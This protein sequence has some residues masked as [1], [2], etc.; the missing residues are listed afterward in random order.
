[1][2]RA[3]QIAQPSCNHYQLR[4]AVVLVAPL[5]G[6]PARSV[7]LLTLGLRLLRVLRLRLLC[8]LRLSLLRALSLLLLPRLRL[9]RALCLCLLRALRLLLLM[10][11]R[12]LRALCLCLLRTLGLLLLTRL[13]LLR[14][15][16]LLLLTRL[17]LLR[18][19]RLRLLPALS[20]LLLTNLRLLLLTNLCLLRLL[21]SLRSLVLRA[22]SSLRLFLRNR[23]CVR[24]L[25][26]TGLRSP[27]TRLA[28]R[29]LT[30]L[31]VR[32]LPR[33]ALGCGL[34]AADPR[35]ER[36]LD[37]AIMRPIVVMLAFEHM[38]L[39]KARIPVTRVG[40][41]VCRKR[42]RRGHRAPVPAIPVSVMLLPSASP[43]LTPTRRSTDGPATEVHRRRDVVANRNPEEEKRDLVGRNGFPRPVV[44][45]AGEPIVAVEHPVHPVI[46]EIVRRE[47]RCVVDRIA[48]NSNELRVGS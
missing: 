26:R 9:L 16:R 25:L 24:L 34:G 22:Y 1:M 4:S 39:R 41:L 47:R 46:E 3:A 27:L 20:L 11:L 45:G 48:G 33:A 15:L 10:R 14:A 17:G 6:A 7:L 5:S 32:P 19:L 31:C 42:C 30:G 29:L 13:G 37:D 44:P 36:L 8:T 18:L 38:L 43:V 23:L 28:Y 21:C 12:L 40:A 2:A 35:I